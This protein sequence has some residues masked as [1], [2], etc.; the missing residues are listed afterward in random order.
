MKFILV[1]FVASLVDF[2]S[3]HRCTRLV[4]KQVSTHS[5][6]HVFS[7]FLKELIDN[8]KFDR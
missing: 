2:K 5:L 7:L 4:C 1:C 8:D 6:A 3:K